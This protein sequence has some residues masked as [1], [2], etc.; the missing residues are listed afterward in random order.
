MANG[1]YIS[2]IQHI[3]HDNYTIQ[4]QLLSNK[5]IHCKTRNE[6]I[7]FL[8]FL[9]IIIGVVFWI[10]NWTFDSF[11]HT[12]WEGYMCRFKDKTCTY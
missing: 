4:E 7:R 2:I 10:A 3:I 9:K 5:P 8:Q 1:I 6:T 12:S 11:H